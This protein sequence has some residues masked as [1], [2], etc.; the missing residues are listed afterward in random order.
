MALQDD[1][2]FN[3]IKGGLAWKGKLERYFISKAPI[4]KPILEWAEE[5]GLEEITVSKLF[6]ATG[7]ALTEDQVL[8]INASIWGFLSNAISG[9]ADTIFKGPIS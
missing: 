8:M 7:D 5:A 6:E 9:P 1:F 3:G 2:K 4:L